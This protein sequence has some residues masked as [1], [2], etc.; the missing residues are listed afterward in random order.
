MH[1]PVMLEEV[2]DLLAPRAGAVLIDLTVGSGG[3]ALA[4]CGRI[5]PDG[6]LLGIDRDAEALERTRARL[7]G[8]C[9]G[10]W[11][12]AHGNF[13]EVGRIALEQGVAEATGVLMDCGVSLEQ[14][15]N[16][17]RGFSLH[18]RGPLDMRMD[19]DQTLTAADLV[20]GLSESDLR[21]LLAAYGEEPAAGRIARALI[22]QRGVAP[23]RETTELAALVER[24][25]GRH[26][27]IH[28][29][30]RTFQALRM[31]VNRELESV[32]AGVHAAVDLL[33]AGGRLA[34]ISFHSVEDRCV[35]C[36]MAEHVGRW[37]S[38]Q[39]G[40][41]RWVGRLPAARWVTRKP[42]V[43]SA[44]EL[45]RNPRAR[46]AKLRVIERVKSREE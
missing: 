30:T 41:R 32:T 10:R 40:G 12:L 7:E 6:F 45:G 3:H 23:L 42:V 14:L 29:A 27:R 8:R 19:R 25:T 26:G 33:A 5:A 34:V 21:R 46:S 38:L 43:P 24:V 17:E 11:V 18:E 2:L 36:A 31:A 13:A 44:A 37:E 15:K 28:P 22:R 1:E 20:N 4:L 16:P 9:G 35:K 39:Q